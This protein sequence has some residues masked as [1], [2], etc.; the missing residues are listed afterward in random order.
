[1]SFHLN[2]QDIRVEDGHLLVGQL[3]N[4]DGDYV[5]ASIDLNEIIGNDEGTSC[6]GPL[7][8]LP[9]PSLSSL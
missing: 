8:S 7:L 3:Q 9:A 5:D 2:S 4:D 6:P 1:M